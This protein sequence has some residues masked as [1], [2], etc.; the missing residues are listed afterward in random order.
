MR[1]GPARR[2]TTWPQPHGLVLVLAAARGRLRAGLVAADRRPALAVHG[3]QGPCAPP[4]RRLVDRRR[5]RLLVPARRV[6]ARGR[7]LQPAD[8]RRH[9]RARSSDAGPGG[10][11]CVRE[12]RAGPGDRS[13][14]LATRRAARRRA[15]WPS[16]CRGCGSGRSGSGTSWRTSAFPLGPQVADPVP[17]RPRRRAG[18]RRGRS[19]RPG[20]GR[21]GRPTIADPG[22]LLGQPRRADRAGRDRRPGAALRPRRRHGVIA[23]RRDAPLAA[24]EAAPRDRRSSRSSCPCTTRARRSSRCSA[25]SPARCQDAARAGRR[26]RLRRRHDR[27]GRRPARERDSAAPRPPERPRPGRP[28]RDEGRHRRH[29]RAVRPDLDGRRLGRAARRRPDGRAREAAAPTSCPPRA[30]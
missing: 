6:R 9:R 7:Q 8:R 12:A 29:E 11:R 1:S 25:P 10:P 5:G 21:L 17:V 22:V 28:Q 13:A 24:A 27:P 30:T 16:R 4:D 3:P 23:A 20:R 19:A 14:G 2:S 15:S 26:L 18:H